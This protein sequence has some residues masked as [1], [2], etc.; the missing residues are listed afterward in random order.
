M[1]DARTY[2]GQP[3]AHVPIVD[4]NTKVS[5]GTS[6]NASGQEGP[7]Q[8]AATQAPVRVNTASR[9]QPPEGAVLPDR[10]WA[11]FQY[12]LNRMFGRPDKVPDLSPA[13]KRDLQRAAMM[14]AIEARDAKISELKHRLY[15]L[16]GIPGLQPIISIIN[17]KG[18]ASKTTTALY[19]GTFISQVTRKT[20]LVL[21]TT[22]N[23]ATSTV[24]AMAGMEPGTTISVSELSRDIK[25]YGA[26]RTVSN[27][28]PRTKPFGLAVVSEDPDDNANVTNEYGVDQFGKMV[29]TILPSLDV[30]ILDG[31]NDNIELGSV[32][33]DAARRSTVLVF[34]STA[35]RGATV[36]KTKSTMAA[37]RTDT[38]IAENMGEHWVPTPEKV[39]HAIVVVSK[40]P[41]GAEVDFDALTQSSTDSPDVP[42]E[43]RTMTIPDDPYMA[44][45]GGTVPVC[46][47]DRI[48]PD[49]QLA[50]LELAVACYEQT[51]KL[52]K[53]ELPE[54]APT[55]FEAVVSEKPVI[56]LAPRA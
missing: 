33:L 47:I 8:T 5:P 25:E 19:V 3:T 12:G 6:R 2:A 34:T 52:L 46:N 43:G 29:E 32:P 20:V 48:Q 16:A 14:R 9:R 21:P 41:Q 23:T 45:D 26:Y 22:S 36:A 40:L 15:W 53:V 42:F 50:Y 18:G 55:S 51:A 37:Y 49:T 54:Y 24:A 27:R 39:K 44:S 13:Q 38:L 7:R 56:R 1:T 31:G 11:K 28:I 30:L 35:D 4:E 17:I 10:G